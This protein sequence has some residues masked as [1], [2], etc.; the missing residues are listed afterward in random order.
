MESDQARAVLFP[1]VAE[2]ADGGRVVVHAWRRHDT[3]GVEL[4]CCGEECLAVAALEL[5]EAR[6]DTAAVTENA[7]RATF[8]VA[9]AGFVGSFKLTQQVNHHVIIFGETLEAGYE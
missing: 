3:Q 2:F 8:P 9:F 4:G 1:D 5:C 7:D 6:N